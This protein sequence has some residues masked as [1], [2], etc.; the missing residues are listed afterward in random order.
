LLLHPAE[1]SGGAKVRGFIERA[2]ERKNR[3]KSNPW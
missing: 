2:K 3:L 1:A